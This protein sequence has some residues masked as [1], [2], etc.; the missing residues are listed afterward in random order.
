MLSWANYHSHTYYC[1]GTSEPIKYIRKALKMGLPAYGYSSHAPVNFPTDWCMPE[2]KLKKYL[3]EIRN[4]KNQFK[5]SIEIYTGLEIDY[6]NG[7]DGM[8]KDRLGEFQL[9]YFI[10][11]VHFV[12]SFANG[13]HWN[14]DTSF[15]LFLKGLKEIYNLNFRKAT[16]EYYETTRRMIEDLQPTIVGHIDKIKMFNPL[17]NFFREDETWYKD[18]IMLTINTLKK[19]NCI[20]EIN[21]RGYYKYNQAELYPSTWIIDLMKKAGIP[22]MINSDSH[23]P[24]EIIKGMSYAA[25][26][27]KALSIDK[28]YALYRNRWSEFNFTE[29]G[30]R[31]S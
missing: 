16:I 12:G 18:Q 6:F 2:E 17:G 5:D 10:G 20:V 25:T 26:K 11:S 15:K 23:H 24:S 14:I 31:F 9:D 3:L 28:I 21:T 1:D 13:M 29:Q 4:L 27:L 8:N 22:L 19:K 7:E 30:I